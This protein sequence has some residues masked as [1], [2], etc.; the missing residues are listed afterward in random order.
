MDLEDRIADLVREGW[1]NPGIEMTLR[2]APSTVSNH[3]SNLYAVAG[4]RVRN[5]RSGSSRIALREYLESEDYRE[6]RESKS[7]EARVRRTLIGKRCPSCRGRLIKYGRPREWR[8]RAQRYLCKE[9][10]L[11]CRD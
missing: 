1:D 6:Y 9:C 7:S 4:I 3:I 8:D 2:I 5:S 11:T 10:G